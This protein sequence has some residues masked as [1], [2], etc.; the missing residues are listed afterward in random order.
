MLCAEVDRDAVH[1][2]CY[3]LEYS[4]DGEAFEGYGA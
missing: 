4:E 1:A 2:C 3:S